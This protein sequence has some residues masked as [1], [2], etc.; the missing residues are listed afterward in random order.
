MTKITNC[1]T[2][3]DLYRKNIMQNK[4]TILIDLDGVL[5][6]YTGGFNRNFIPPIKNGAKDFIKN[7]TEKFE[8][9]LFT[10]RNKILASK[11]IINNGLEPYIK[12][13]TNIKEVAWL[14]IDDRCLNFQ[15]DYDEIFKKINEFKVWYK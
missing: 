12:D 2:D 9:K 11:W 6:Q 14:Y 15:G 1:P 5:N 7:L 13:V 10:T 4:K 8:I 3:K